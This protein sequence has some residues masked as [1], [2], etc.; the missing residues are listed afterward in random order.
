MTLPSSPNP[1]SAGQIRSEFGASG[2][3]NS[4]SLGNYR[5]SSTVGTYSNLPLDD[6][7]PTSGPINFNSFRGKSLNVVLDLGTATE[8][9]INLKNIYDN[10]TPTMVGGYATKPINTSGKKI[11]FSVDNKV[12]G[13][14]AGSITNVALRTGG[15]NTGTSL[16]LRIGSGGQIYGAGGAG[17]GTI[18]ASTVAGGTQVFCENCIYFIITD[19]GFAG[20][21]WC[22]GVAL[23]DPTGPNGE[24]AYNIGGFYPGDP[25]TIGDAGGYYQARRDYQYTATSYGTTPG[26]NGSSAIGIDY[27]I[28]IEN[29]GVIQ[30]GYGGGGS[31]NVATATQ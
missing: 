4:V 2:A 5:V 24:A 12:I 27:P 20:P 29:Y 9:R 7:I 19:G 15:W 23:P 22:D 25:C 8:Y 14:D 21:I 17:G 31:G 13:S 16:Q 11:K 26:S 6:G 10:S 1:I 28:T 18:A 3:S 30:S